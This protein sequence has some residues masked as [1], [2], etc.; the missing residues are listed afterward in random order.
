MTV[1]GFSLPYFTLLELTSPESAQPVGFDTKADLKI[2]TLAFPG[3][4][5][6]LGFPLM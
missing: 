6:K 3:E 1:Q 2:S 4:P 5:V